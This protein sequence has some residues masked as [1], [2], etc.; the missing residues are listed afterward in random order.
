MILMTNN[1]IID[2]VNYKVI[3]QYQASKDLL[4]NAITLDI[5]D[6]NKIAVKKE[7]RDYLFKHELKG[8]TEEIGSIVL[9][10]DLFVI[11]VKSNRVFRARQ[12]LVSDD[13]YRRAISLK[14]EE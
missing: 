14:D 10:E 1:K 6:F 11:D 4:K 7:N 12:Q 2:S 3:D 5:A 9:S 13:I 8:L